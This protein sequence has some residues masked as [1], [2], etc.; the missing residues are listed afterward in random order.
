MVPTPELPLPLSEAPELHSTAIQDGAQR[1]LLIIFEELEN[2]RRHYH[3]ERAELKQ[4]FSRERLRVERA[5]QEAEGLSQSLEQDMSRLREEYSAARLDAE[6]ARQQHQVARR[7]AEEHAR[8]LVQLQQG[9]SS[10]ITSMSAYMEPDV[11]DTEIERISPA[12]EDTTSLLSAQEAFDSLEKLALRLLKRLEPEQDRYQNLEQ[13]H[14][15]LEKEHNKLGAVHALSQSSMLE[16]RNAAEQTLKDAEQSRSEVTESAEIVAL[17]ARLKDA[18][19]E[20]EHAKAGTAAADRLIAQM[21]AENL[22][23]RVAELETGLRE[24][25]AKDAAKVSSK[26]SQIISLN[27]SLLQQ[28]RATELSQAVEKEL[29]R[30]IT[31]L[32][33]DLRTSRLREQAD[34]AAA[35]DVGGRNS[36]DSAALIEELLRRNADLEKQLGKA[37]LAASN[38]TTALQAS[39]FGNELHLTAGQNGSSMAASIASPTKQHSHEKLATSLTALDN[40][41]TVATNVCAYFFSFLFYVTV[42][43]ISIEQCRLHSHNPS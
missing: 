14:N 15:L 35:Q 24:A 36:Q 23:R 20:I 5:R 13:R 30:K 11:S 38:D 19:E 28:A 6:Q 4:H 9:I 39:P 37:T 34:R 42:E 3:R 41:S 7:S 22:K 31:I 12:L 27:A 10:F 18:Q 29:R 32:E 17:A 2:A 8:S 40:A 21:E 16:E 43:C 33:E 25:A 26:Q 1:Q